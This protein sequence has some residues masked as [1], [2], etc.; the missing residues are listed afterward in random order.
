MWWF[1]VCCKFMFFLMK[2]FLMVCGL[3]FSKLI[4]CDLVGV[5]V[6]LFLVIGNFGY[7]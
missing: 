2:K 7:D 5:I 4:M 3:L 6:L 1:V